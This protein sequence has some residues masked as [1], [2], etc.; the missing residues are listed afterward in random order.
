MSFFI[1]LVSQLPN[2][3]QVALDGLQRQLEEAVQRQTTMIEDKIRAFTAE[4]YQMLEQFRERAH[5][6]HRLLSKYDLTSMCILL[7]YNNNRNLVFFFIIRLVC[8]GEETNRVTN[9]IE[10]PPTTP[11]GFKSTLI[12]SAANTVNPKSNILFNDTKVSSDPNVKHDTI[13][14]HYSK[15]TINV[16]HFCYIKFF[17]V[18]LDIWT[19]DQNL[20]NHKLG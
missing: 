3:V 20:Y 17:R 5:N 6:E 11:D 14:E 10:T 13:T 2:T 9:N 18:L 4:Q 15:S 19:T 12:T 1:Y 16:S 7:L 8:R